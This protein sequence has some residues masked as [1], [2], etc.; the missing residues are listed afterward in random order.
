[1]NFSDN[2]NFYPTPKAIID[3]MIA[4]FIYI[5]SETKTEEGVVDWDITIHTIKTIIK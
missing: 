5:K 3:K 4:P 1:M 2:P